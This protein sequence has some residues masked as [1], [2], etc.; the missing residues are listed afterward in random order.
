[1][2]DMTAARLLLVDDVSQVRQELRTLL[3]L[4]GDI[5]IV[6]EA[7]NGLAALEQCEALEPEAI[8]MDLEMPEMDGYEATRQIKTLHPGCRV[9][10]L[11]VHGYDH[12]RQKALQAGADAFVVKGASL[13]S[14]LQAIQPKDKTSEVFQILQVSSN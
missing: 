3:S 2:T 9:V 14:L 13:E 7:A 5:E 6:G 4:V 11:T 10:V 12:A 8:L 1:M